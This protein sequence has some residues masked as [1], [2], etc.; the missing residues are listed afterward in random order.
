VNEAQCYRIVDTRAGLG[1]PLMR[2]CERCGSNDVL[3]HHHRVK[4]SHGGGHDPSNVVLLCGSC[5][6]WV[7]H[8]DDNA[9][10]EGWAVHAPTDPATVAV[11][12]HPMQMRVR[13]DDEGLLVPER[14]N[15]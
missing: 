4:R 7:E 2:R 5:H 15:G 13:F 6:P 3:T 9:T 1:D 10:V 11:Y 8:H 12:H 14:E